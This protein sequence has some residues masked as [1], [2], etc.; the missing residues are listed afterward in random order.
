MKSKKADESAKVSQR[1][2]I[3]DSLSVRSLKWTEKQK[4]FIEL[5]TN[6]DTRIIFVNGPA[7]TS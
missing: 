7:G 2:K 3:K 1:E 5:A 6:K 4:Q